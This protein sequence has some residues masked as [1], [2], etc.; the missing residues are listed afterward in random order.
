MG[1]Q[2]RK[3]SKNKAKKTPLL[4]SA[5]NQGKTAKL[6]VFP[7]FFLSMSSLAEIHCPLHNIF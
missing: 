7:D 5:K 1:T 6:E 3:E 4:E 2:F